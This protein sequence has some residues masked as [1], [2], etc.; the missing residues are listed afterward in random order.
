MTFLWLCITFVI[1]RALSQNFWG[2]DMRRRDIMRGKVYKAWLP[3]NWFYSSFINWWSLPPPTLHLPTLPLRWG[4]ACL[5][6]NPSS[7]GCSSWGD[8][9]ALIGKVIAGGTRCH[10]GPLLSF[11]PSGS[12]LN[13]A[14]FLTLSPYKS[15]SPAG[16]QAAGTL[17]S[18]GL[19][20]TWTL[21]W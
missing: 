15:E 20:F 2:K 8:G 6:G 11:H 16:L 18:S 19:L 7:G 13:K 17:T 10:Q 12:G 9:R 3:H 1:I 4:S 14:I 21:L 5:E